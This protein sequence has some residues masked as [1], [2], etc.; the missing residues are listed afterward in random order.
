MPVG[1][2]DFK[3]LVQ[4]EYYFVDKTRFIRD[5]LDIRTDVTLITR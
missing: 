3:K 2:E 5:L 4:G 1:I